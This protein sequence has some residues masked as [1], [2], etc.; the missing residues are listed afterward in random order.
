[1]VSGSERGRHVEQELNKGRKR[2]LERIG[3]SRGGQTLSEPSR[4][5]KKKQVEKSLYS[6]NR[7][8]KSRWSP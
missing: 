5:K 1:M 7:G 6:H 3:A 2:F 8:H 4:E